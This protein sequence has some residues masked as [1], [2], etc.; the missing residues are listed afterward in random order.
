M[1]DK[2]KNNNG[3]SLLEVI[4]V[5]ATITIMAGILLTAINGSRKKAIHNICINNQRELNASIL[6]YA[7]DENHY[8]TKI[9]KLKFK[10]QEPMNTSLWSQSLYANNVLHYIDNSNILNCPINQ[11]QATSYGINQEIQN[12]NYAEITNTSETM[13]TCD[14]NSEIITNINQ[15]EYRHQLSAIASFADGHVKTI[16]NGAFFNI[17]GGGISIS[18]SADEPGPSLT[19]TPPSKGPGLSQTP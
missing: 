12:K 9:A 10:N 6:L 1:N 19:P 13:V 5:M 4:T 2:F 15:I 7:L 18:P 17:S 8:P 11:N 16:K 3:L 14:S